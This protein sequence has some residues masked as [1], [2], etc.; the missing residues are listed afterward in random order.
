MNCLNA[1]WIKSLFRISRVNNGGI[2]IFII[3]LILITII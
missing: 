1:V 3:I 2:I